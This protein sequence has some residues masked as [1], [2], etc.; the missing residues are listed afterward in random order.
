MHG[1]SH[2]DYCDFIYHIPELREK[3]KRP[4]NG[5][6]DY[7]DENSDF[8]DSTEYENFE[9]NLGSVNDMRLNFQMRAL[10]SIQYQAGLAVIESRRCGVNRN[11]TSA[12][13]ATTTTT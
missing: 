11:Y 4:E 8:D 3:K 1:R 7:Y 13:T 10:E 6:E 5:L 2:L 9:A 12:S